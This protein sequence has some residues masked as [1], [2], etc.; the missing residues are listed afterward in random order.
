MINYGIAALLKVETDIIAVI[1]ARLIGRTVIQN[2][3]VCE[4]LESGC[5]CF[6]WLHNNVCDIILTNNFQY[7]TEWDLR[8]NV[9]LYNNVLHSVAKRTAFY[10][11]PQL[12]LFYCHFPA[13]K[14]NLL[15]LAVLVIVLR[16][17]K[18]HVIKLCYK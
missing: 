14:L 5:Y 15:D 7:Q 3:N 2:D 13:K 6:Y 9:P 18:I 17:I 1:S 11:F 16:L 10:P 4:D 12:I 8:Q